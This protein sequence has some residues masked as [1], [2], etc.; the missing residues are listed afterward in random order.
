MDCTCCNVRL[1]SQFRKSISLSA[2]VVITGQRSF[3]LAIDTYLVLIG[4]LNLN[5]GKNIFYQYH[6]TFSSKAATY[7]PQ[8]NIP[9]TLG[10]TVVSTVTSQQEG[11]GFVCYPSPHVGV[12]QFSPTPQKHA[13]KSSCPGITSG[14]GSRA[15]L[16]GSP[17]LL[18]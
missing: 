4:E 1:T 14:V 3:Q 17:L 12:L 6:R 13:T 15:I 7:I 8:A 5:Y 2:S 10:G 18:A 9:L 16:C 11:P